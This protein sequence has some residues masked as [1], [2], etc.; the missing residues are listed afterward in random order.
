MM[1]T[2]VMMMMKRLAPACLSDDQLPPTTV[3]T[4]RRG[5][6]FVAIKNA[7]RFNRGEENE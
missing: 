7:K 5:K 3:S 1:M 6:I 2:Q 4:L